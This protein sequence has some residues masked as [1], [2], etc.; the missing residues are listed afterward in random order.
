MSTR[1]QDD[2]SLSS[3]PPETPW[4]GATSSPDFDNQKHKSP[5]LNYG[6]H[7]VTTKPNRHFDRHFTAPVH[8]KVLL[9][10]KTFCDR[11]QAEVFKGVKK[12]RM[13]YAEQ[14]EYIDQLLMEHV[15]EL[16]YKV[17][18]MEE[19]NAALKERNA[20]LEAGTVDYYDTIDEVEE[21]E[22]V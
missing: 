1:L 9:K 15:S 6:Q 2:A 13:A 12:L 17:T 22:L 8:N 4:I 16:R 20:V 18:A 21:D 3:E 11:P 7:R 10:Y 19:E 14:I 5:S